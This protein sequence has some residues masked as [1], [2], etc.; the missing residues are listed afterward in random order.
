MPHGTVFQTQYSIDNA[1]IDGNVEV[2]SMARGCSD[3]GDNWFEFVHAQ[4]R[5]RTD[6]TAIAKDVLPGYDD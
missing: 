2:L 1:L 6:V 5:N 4:K 3:A